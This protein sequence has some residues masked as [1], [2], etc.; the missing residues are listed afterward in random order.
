[1]A[2]DRQVRRLSPAPFAP[3]VN[4]AAGLRGQG[5]MGV[6]DLIDD[7]EAL[8]RRW[9]RTCSLRGDGIPDA[10]HEAGIRAISLSGRMCWSVVR[11]GCPVSG[12][13]GG[14]AHMA[15]EGTP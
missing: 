10:P 12:T 5:S 13:L 9:P 4:D 3:E 14:K 15:P 6:D 8:L 7:M 1:M 11:D 2:G